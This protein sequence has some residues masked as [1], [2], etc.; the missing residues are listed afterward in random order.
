[1]ALDDVL[2]RRC[3]LRS[4]LERMSDRA[5]G[6][7]VM[8]ILVEE[9]ERGS[10]KGLLSIATHERCEVHVDVARAA[11]KRPTNPVLE[12]SSRAFE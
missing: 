7:S 2:S 5:W 3:E 9:R 11:M 1:M 6:R 4:R 10:C 12:Y 8:V